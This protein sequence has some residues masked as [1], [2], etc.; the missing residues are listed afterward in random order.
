LKSALFTSRDEGKGRKT[1]HL[2][3]MKGSQ[4][5][6]KRRETQKTLPLR[7]KKLTFKKNSFERRTEGK[8]KGGALP[9]LQRGLDRNLHDTNRERN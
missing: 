2:K 1:P 5:G 3:I 7:K 9:A 4:I 8:K 6:K